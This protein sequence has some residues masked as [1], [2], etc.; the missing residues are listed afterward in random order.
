MPVAKTLEPFVCG[1]SAA[2][3][4]SIVIHPM[5]LAK[6]RKFR[7]S[8]RNLRANHTHPLVSFLKFQVRMQLYGQLNPGKPV[9]SFV[10]II[11][12]SVKNDGIGGIYKG[13][14]AAGK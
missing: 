2:T 6:V 7:C 8:V 1:G 4:A 14:D 9:P 11:S 10:E 12:T 3:F 5:D 13:V